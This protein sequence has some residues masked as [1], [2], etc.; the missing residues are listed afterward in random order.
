MTLTTREES[1]TKAQCFFIK[2]VRQRKW[3]LVKRALSSDDV[4]AR[5][6]H[7]PICTHCGESHSVLMLLCR[8]DPPLK[9]VESLLRSNPSTAFEKDCIKRTPL[10]MA[11]EFGASP[12]IVEKLLKQNPKGVKERDSSGRLPIHLACISYSKSMGTRVPQAII[13]N[14]LLEVLRLLLNHDPASILEKD[15]D[16][17]C[18]IESAILAGV[19]ANIVHSLQKASETVRKKEPFQFFSSIA[20]GECRTKPM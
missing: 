2:T 6:W 10:H 5:K 18:P 19:N 20:W 3:K 13:Q 7:S 11:C 15:R 4:R 8:H 17:I 9:L 14:S 12:A 1:S 16:Q